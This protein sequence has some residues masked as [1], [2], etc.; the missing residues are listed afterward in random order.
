MISV[1]NGIKTELSKT[2]SRKIAKQMQGS[3]FRGF[4]ASGLEGAEA[5]GQAAFVFIILFVHGGI[6]LEGRLAGV[7]GKCFR[8]MAEWLVIR[9]LCTY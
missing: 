4:G 5:G 6:R 1:K 2:V 9:I 7:M 3:C 8:I